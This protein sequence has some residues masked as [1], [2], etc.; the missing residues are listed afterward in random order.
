MYYA[1]IF[2]FFHLIC[3]YLFLEELN[4]GLVFR[5][6]NLAIAYALTRI[7]GKNTFTYS[8]ELAF[9]VIF[10]K[11]AGMA[12]RFK[13]I[14]IF[15]GYKINQSNTNPFLKLSQTLNKLFFQE[16]NSENILLIPCSNSLAVIC[17]GLLQL[18]LGL[19]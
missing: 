15:Y 14:D 9:G 6:P 16:V 2:Q 1:P 11:G 3:N 5:G 4:Y 19:N 18:K 7:S 8:P 13:P 10:N 17:F 12:L